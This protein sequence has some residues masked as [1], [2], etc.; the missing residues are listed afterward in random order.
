MPFV[1]QNTFLARDTGAAKTGQQGPLT[2]RRQRAISSRSNLPGFP[3]IPPA[4]YET[5]EEMSKAPTLFLAKTIVTAPVRRNNWTWCQ[6]KKCPQKWADLCKDNLDPL[7]MA[8]VRDGLRA[9]E[10]EMAAFELVWTRKNGLTWLQ[11]LKPLAEYPHTKILTDDGGNV[12]G[13]DNKSKGSEGKEGKEV[14]LS[15]DNC[16]IYRNEPTVLRPYG[17]SRYENC[18][19]DW[20]RSKHLGEKLAQYLGKIAGIIVQCHYPDGTGKDASGADRP[21]FWLAEELLENVAVGRSVAIPNKF[22]S[23]LAGDDGMGP[24][25]ASMERALAAAGKSDWVLS[26]FDPGGTDYSKGFLDTLAYYDKL[27]FRGWGRGE[28]SGLEADKGGIGTSDAGT[29]TDTGLLDAELI[30]QDFCAA[31]SK[32]VIDKLLTQ[33]FGDNAAGAVWVEPSPLVDTTVQT[34][35]ALLTTAMASPLIAPLVSKIIDWGQ[36][37]ENADVPLV[38]DVAGAIASV[39]NAAQNAA[40]DPNA[41]AEVQSMMRKMNDEIKLMRREWASGNGRH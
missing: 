19:P 4:T 1:G 3:L 16:F 10:F 27:M 14:K 41:S 5:F 8:A 29:H 23:F 25:P 37:G 34:A 28:R 6:S 36:V 9:L 39:Q 15:N 2:P 22:A 35:S 33:N 20:S 21:N 38:N 32:G 13:L 40:A 17:Y 18:L 30:D 31:F 12:I 24:T 7:R 11:R 26:A